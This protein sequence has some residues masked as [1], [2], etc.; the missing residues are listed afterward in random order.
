LSRI[1]WWTVLA[2]AGLLV[3]W[4]L[5]TVGASWGLTGWEM[6]GAVAAGGLLGPVVRRRG[7]T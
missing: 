6:A 4:G 3:G 5:G 7:P 2:M 1:A